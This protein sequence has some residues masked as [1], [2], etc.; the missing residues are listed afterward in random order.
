MVASKS[1][2]PHPMATQLARLLSRSDPA[3]LAE[4]VRR[5][6]HEAPDERQRLRY[7]E[8]GERL[9]DM[10]RALAEAGARPSQEELELALSLMLNLAA[11]SPRG[12]SSTP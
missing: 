3:E 6:L 8:L 2:P 7:R 11:Q 1:G 5:W 12:S 10:K 9:V 4:V